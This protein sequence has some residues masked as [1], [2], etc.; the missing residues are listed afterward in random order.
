MEPNFAISAPFATA[1]LVAGRTSI[2]LPQRAMKTA[3]APAA[4]SDLCVRDTAPIFQAQDVAR[5]VDQL[6][7]SG[8]SATLATKN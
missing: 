2:F 1:H 6:S 5:R 7:A 8:C 4:R 3:P